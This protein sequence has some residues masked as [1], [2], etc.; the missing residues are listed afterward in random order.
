MQ[1]FSFR[2]G[3]PVDLTS[4]QIEGERLILKSIDAGY[5]AE[6]FREFSPEITRYMLPKPAD[7]IDETLAFI[8][9][10]LDRMRK[11]CDLVLAITLKEN[12]DF[13]GC[14]G[15]HGIADV[16]IPVLGIWIKKAAHGNKYGREAIRILTAWAA[17]TIDFDY[18]RYP[19]DKDNIASRKIPEELG[20]AI[21][22]E[23]KVRTMRGTYLNEVVYR[24]SYEALKQ[25]HG[26]LATD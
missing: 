15:F 11:G 24:I 17:E 12:G 18:V 2:G 6:I 19:V 23:Q 5:S 14:C 7:T 1:S 26:G 13:L 25:F 8:S 4:L 22:E 16:R 20:A 9:E 3:R 10:S 21:C